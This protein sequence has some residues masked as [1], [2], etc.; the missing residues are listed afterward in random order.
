MMY[1]IYY[2]L[3]IFYIYIFFKLLFINYELKMIIVLIL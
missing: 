1:Y 2:Y 3:L